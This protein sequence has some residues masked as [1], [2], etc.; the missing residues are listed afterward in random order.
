MMWLQ[1]S[2]SSTSMALTR[3]SSPITL[4][5]SSMSPEMRL[6]I[7]RVICSSTRPPIWS[8][9]ERTRSSSASNCLDVCSAMARAYQREMTEMLRLSGGEG[10]DAARLGE[11]QD[12]GRSLCEKSVGHQAGQVVQIS[13]QLGRIEDRQ[14]VA[15]DDQ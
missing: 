13:L 8:T 9:R 10:S 7:A 11:Q 5:M 15:I 1:A 3:W 4:S 2:S 12:V 6:S 14:P